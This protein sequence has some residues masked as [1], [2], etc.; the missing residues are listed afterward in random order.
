[1]PATEGDVI[2]LLES[3]R[4]SVCVIEEVG[5]YAGGAGA[6]GS[7]MFNFGRGYGFIIGVMM[8]TKIPIELIRPQKW[9][10]SFGVGTKASCKSSTV[11]KN[12]L[13]SKAQQLFPSQKVTL[14]TADALLI[15]SYYFNSRNQK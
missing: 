15:L 8:A 4:P 7:A 10:K 12:K 11:W 9:Q 5:G 14:K 3:I 6:P 13:K 1:M 2:E